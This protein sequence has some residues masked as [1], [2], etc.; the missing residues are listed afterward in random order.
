[1]FRWNLI[2]GLTWDKTV[3]KY[4]FRILKIE[5]FLKHKYVLALQSHTKRQKWNAVNG[6]NKFLFIKIIRP[7][8]TFL[9]YTKLRFKRNHLFFSLHS[10]NYP[11]FFLPIFQ[12]SADIWFMQWTFSSVLKL[13]SITMIYAFLFLYVFHL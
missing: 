7:R 1:M 2:A 4:Y 12:E 11:F 9:F 5:Y 6:G 10:K 8:K 3:L 13:K